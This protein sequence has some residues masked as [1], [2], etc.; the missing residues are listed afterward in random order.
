M[1]RRSPPSGNGA[2]APHSDDAGALYLERARALAPQIASS[3]M[4]IE[5]E[6]RIPAPLQQA[7][8]DAQLFRMFL[9]RSLGGPE[10]HPLTFMEVV[11]TLARADA[12]PAWNVCQ[13]TVC[14]LIAGYLQPEVARAIFSDPAAI[15]AWGPPDGA[16]R[17]IVENGGYRINGSWS[18]ASGGRHAT[19]LGAYCPVHE[20]DGTPRRTAKGDVLRRVM[21][22]PAERATMTDVWDVIGLRGTA[23]DAF[24][25]KDLYVPQEYSVMRDDISE[26]RESGWLYRFKTTNLYSCG[27]ASLAIGV[28]RTMLDAFMR[29]ATEKTP[30]GYS[31]TLRE[32]A[33]TQSD[34]AQAEA[35]LRAA[36]AYLRQTVGEICDDVRQTGNE[37]TME[38][39]MAIRLT[40]THAIR[41]STLVADFAYEAAGASAIF[42]ANAFEK[43]FR[44]LHTICQQ[45]QGR[46]S[47]FQTV[48]K[49]LLGLE[50]ETLFL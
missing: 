28:A 14:G 26:V 48:G 35:N 41:Q 20:A 5:R 23:S 9:P 30:R 49:F 32:N 39:R 25:V 8:V 17:A 42:R 34:F 19:W 40:T 7:L 37:L 4:D 33:A 44:D 47:H 43:R 16:T 6:R 31:S 3:S 29:L 45:V 46:K 27:F 11:E 18:F 15:L 24:A 2:D 50:G 12:S 10:L 22:F 38:Q 1:A 36:R 21:L 13:N